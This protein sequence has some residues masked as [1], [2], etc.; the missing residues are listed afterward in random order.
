[1]AP[2]VRMA[3]Q[4]STE[5]NDPPTNERRVV[6][7]TFGPFRVL[8][9]ERLLFRDGEPI[10]IMPKVFDTL[11]VLVRHGGQLLSKDELL[12]LIWHGSAIE[13]G[14]LTQNIFM[15]RKILGEGPHDH[16]YLVTIPTMG[17]RFVAKVTKVYDE[18]AAHAPGAHGLGG[19][20]PSAAKLSLAVLPFTP[21]GS[22]GGGEELDEVGIADTL[23][24]RLSA[25]GRVVV[26]PTHAIL[27]AVG[28]RPDLLAAG[29][30]LLVDAVLSGTIQHSRESVRV[31]IQ[32]VDT[33]DGNTFWAAQV[34][35]KL[36]DVFAVQDSISERIVR[37]FRAEFD[38]GA[39]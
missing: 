34:D 9:A 35:E 21:L 31:N 19:R 7:Y 39:E 30:E 10:P 23:I 8:P 11:L 5:P 1:M 15:L 27:T 28:T 18:R 36:S 3:P 22:T 24:T 4:H 14:N 2:P 20:F 12:R 16:R 38:A 33:A 37:A 25:L 13:M 6:G 17:Y 29:R 26:R 32:L